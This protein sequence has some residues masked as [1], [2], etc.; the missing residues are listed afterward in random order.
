MPAEM[1]E[2][3]K[4]RSQWAMLETRT[5]FKTP[6]AEMREQAKGR[7]QWAMLD[8]SARLI[9]SPASEPA[10]A[11]SDRIIIAGDRFFIVNGASI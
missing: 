5:L 8:K 2:Q 1:R 7:S 4:G 10:A 9:Q 3:A 6:K 11:A